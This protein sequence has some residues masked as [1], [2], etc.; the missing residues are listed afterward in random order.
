MNYRFDNNQYFISLDPGD[1]INSSFEKIAKTEGIQS[2][3]I[4]GIGAL[5]NME[6]GYYDIETK[7]YIRKEYSED[8]EL[9]SLSGNITLKDG[10][11]YSHTHITFSD[12]EFNVF[13][14]HLFSGVISAAGEFVMTVGTKPLNRAFNCN[15]GLA[16]WCIEK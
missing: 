7:S 4:S 12:R 2:A 11:V 16:L 9:T 5:T 6:M 8:Y 14:G 1:E 10:E 3:W 13:G 15:I